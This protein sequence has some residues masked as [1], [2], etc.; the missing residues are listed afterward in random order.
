MD[1]S[2]QPTG[3][4]AF[5]IILLLV[6]VIPIAYLSNWALH[7]DSIRAF[8]ISAILMFFILLTL[9]LDFFKYLFPKGSSFSQNAFS[10]WLG[11]GLGT[12][13][14]FISSRSHF[15]LFTIPKQQLLSQLSGQL[16]LFWDKYINTIG[17]AFTEEIMFLVS[18]P[19]V[20]FFILNW[21]GE[22]IELFKNPIFQTILV[23]A[24]VSPL[25]AIFHVGEAGLMSFFISAILFRSFLIISVQGDRLFNLIPFITLTVSFA[26]GFH[27]MNN[28]MV[29]GGISEFIK[30]MSSNIWG[31]VVLI[32]LSLT[33]VS[34]LIY[35][36]KPFRK[37]L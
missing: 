1:I 25:F 10:L 2:D 28:V 12:L 5:W 31:V 21:I 20:L 23:A 17:A 7:N 22:K 34:S 32:F 14:Y 35:L 8:V 18:I 4:A 37:G 16:P 13:L 30:I 24:I 6:S 27:M 11:I 9:S 15:A 26:V 19:L 29:S 36:M 3:G 33:F